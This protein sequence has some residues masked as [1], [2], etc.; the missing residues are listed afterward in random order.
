VLRH[1]DLAVH[2]GGSGTIL[3]ALVHGTPQVVVPK[4]ADQFWNADLVAQAGL[5]AA[6]EPA[7]VTVDAVAG[8]AAGELATDRPAVAAVREEL[9]ALPEPSEVVAE[10]A[11]RIGWRSGAP[12]A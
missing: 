10:L 6:L 5:A 9:A 7:H 8:A 3:G 11:D 12:A 2:H 1:A 4:G